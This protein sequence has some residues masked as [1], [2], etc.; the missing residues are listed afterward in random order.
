[1]FMLPRNGVGHENDQ[2]HA[3]GLQRP[4]RYEVRPLEDGGI[5]QGPTQAAWMTRILRGARPPRESTGSKH[6][7]LVAHG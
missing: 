4:K 5:W 7:V 6:G 2:A 3:N 1:M